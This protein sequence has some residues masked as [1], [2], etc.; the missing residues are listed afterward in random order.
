MDFLNL[1]CF[2]VGDGTAGTERFLSSFL[3]QFPETSLV[4][5]CGEPLSRSFKAAGFSY[6]A[7]DHIFISHLHSDHFGGFFM[8]LQSLWLQGRT[9]PLT[10]H[11]PGEGIAPVRQML[12]ASYLFDELLPFTLTFQPHKAGKSATVGTVQVTPFKTTH[13]ADLEKRYSARYPGSYEAF[14]FLMESPG[15]RI[16]HS[17]D[18]GSPRDLDSLLERPLDLLVCELAHFTPEELFASLRGRSVRT[19]A[20]IHLASEYWAN[21]EGLLQHAR[22]KLPETE[23]VIASDNGTVAVKGL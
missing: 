4:L 8:F 5:D 12:N 2:G 22:R 19:L 9:R 7:F 15:L 20:F 3:Y 16:G 6:D 14:C 18:L 17:G 13:L 11:L 1:K 21:R 10:V 23:I